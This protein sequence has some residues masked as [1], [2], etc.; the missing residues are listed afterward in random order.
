[1]LPITT[2]GYS[3]S[4]EWIKEGG[5]CTKERGYCILQCHLAH[6]RVVHHS[7]PGGHWQG[8]GSSCKGSRKP[9]TGL[10]ISPELAEAA[11]HMPPLTIN[12]NPWG[13]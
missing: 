8:L 11:T 10:Q 3:V 5:K 6:C 9:D 4:E 7:I 1:M 13:P 12:W 2:G